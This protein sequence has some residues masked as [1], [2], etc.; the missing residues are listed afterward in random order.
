MGLYGDEDPW[1]V[2]STVVVGVPSIVTAGIGALVTLCLVLRISFMSD[3][4]PD[5]GTEERKKTN[6]K[7]RQ[8]GTAISSGATT[9]LLKEYTYLV[10][11]ALALFVLVAAAVNWRTGIW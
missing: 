3:Q 10:V 2:L 11:V 7:I 6:I 8:L 1:F 9:F 5:D 4:L